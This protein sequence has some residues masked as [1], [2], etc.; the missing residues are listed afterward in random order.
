MDQETIQKLAAEIA[1]HLPDY[2]WWLLA[3]QVV[4]TLLAAAAGA[5][6]GEYFK[7]RGK[8][9]ATRA[10][11]E[12][13][14]AQ[15][16]ANTELVETIKSEVGHRDWAKRERTNQRRIKLEEL[17]NKLHDCDHYLDEL[18]SSALDAKFFSGRDPQP[19]LATIAAL[20]FPE[21]KK[22]ADAYVAQFRK[23]KSDSLQLTVT[24]M[25]LNPS[26]NDA[27]LKASNDYMASYD[28]TYKALLNADH[29]LQRAAAKLLREIMGVAE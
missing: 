29:D 5:F 1:Q 21:L 25:R 16:R 26:D 12:S 6:F 9:L 27:R 10:D 2:S 17:L 15:L 11:F 18:R 3:I 7:T 13:L 14:K 4:L 20:Y 22:E 28:L 23:Q 8:N 19:E 24:V